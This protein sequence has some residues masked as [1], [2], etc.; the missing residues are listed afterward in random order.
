MFSKLLKINYLSFAINTSVF[1]SG[2]VVMAFEL[3]GSRI[4][5]PYLGNSITVWTSLIGVILAFLSLGYYVGGKAADKKSDVKI[6]SLFLLISAFFIAFTLLIKD[7]VLGLINPSYNLELYSIIVSATLFG[8]AGFFL[9]LIAPYATRLKINN[10]KGAGG[11]IGSVYALSTLGSIF[12]TFLAGM[13]LIPFFGSTKIIIILVLAQCLNAL[14]YFKYWNL[15][16]YIFPAILFF[17]IFIPARSESHVIYDEDTKYGRVQVVRGV[18]PKTGREA[19]YLKEDIFGL[20]AAS[21]LDSDELVFEIIKFFTLADYFKPQPNDALMI[22]GGTFSYPTYF[23]S[24]NPKAVIDVV[25]INP[26]LTR[27]AKD[28]FNFKENPRLNIIN[29]DGR[30]FLNSNDKKY[31][32]I[33]ID[34]YKSD[35]SAPF[36]LATKEAVRKVSESLKANGIVVANIIGSTEGSKSRFLKSTVSTYKE[37][38]STVRLF[39]TQSDDP[40][41]IQN[42]MLVAYN[43]VD[44]NDA[45]KNKYSNFLKREYKKNIDSGLILTDDYAPVEF[46]MRR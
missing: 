16:M 1:I 8:P 27:I 24:K 3:T 20:Q 44:I 29:Q 45:A 36:Q 32:H 4:V 31:D 42:I 39:L 34:A 33:Y 41:E 15:K 38:F 2:G 14:L 18:D 11:Q 10:L 13:F 12:G 43:D 23:V 9:G 30:L 40:L 6:F 25:E 5:A 7:F 19:N 35:T 28:Y 17:T 26:D 22:G 37:E 46:L 21:F